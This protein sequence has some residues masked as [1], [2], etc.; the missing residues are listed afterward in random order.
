MGR[1]A[2]TGHVVDTDDNL[3]LFILSAEN[4]EDGTEQGARSL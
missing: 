2:C 4:T 3:Q 1:G